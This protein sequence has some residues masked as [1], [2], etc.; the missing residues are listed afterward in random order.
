MAFSCF[1]IQF[2]PIDNQ[3]FAKIYI[4]VV[5]AFYFSPQF[6]WYMSLGLPWSPFFHFRPLYLLSYLPPSSFIT[7]S[8]VSRSLFSSHA[9]SFAVAITLT[10]TLPACLSLRPTGQM[11]CRRR[12]HIWRAWWK[13]WMPSQPPESINLH[14]HNLWEK[15][16]G[17]ERKQ[18]HYFLSEGQGDVLHIFW[19][20]ISRW[21]KKLQRK[22]VQRQVSLIKSKYSEETGRF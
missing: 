22:A 8:I 1:N 11:S 2:H 17:F 12:W 18:P 20:W 3:C 14:K 21:G 13:T 9:A 5:F 16:Q 7:R 15:T 19:F 4:F 10:P 6:H